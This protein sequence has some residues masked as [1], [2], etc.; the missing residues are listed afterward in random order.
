MRKERQLG[1][2]TV[3]VLQTVDR[4]SR[5][6]FDI[7]E[8]TGL[9]SGTVYEVLASRLMGRSGG[10]LQVFPTTPGIQ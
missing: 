10:R 8:Q 7:I 3:R 1:Y 9:P 6:G 4:G 2:A 5:Y